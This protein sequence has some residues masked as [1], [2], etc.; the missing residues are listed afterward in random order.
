MAELT[1]LREALAAEQA[2]VYGY[3]VVGAHLSGKA[4]KYAA[5]RLVAHQEL[6]DQLAALIQQ[7]GAVPASA[8]PA[9]Q[10]PF[11]VTDAVEARRLGGTLENGSAGAA[12]DLTAAT[13][14]AS[15]GRQLAVDWLIDVAKAAAL[16][17]ASN[18]L[19]G[20]SA[21]S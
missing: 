17:G 18:A 1:A 20:Q 16:W 19:P 10:L 7:I 5:A 14:S 4:E 11:P 9:Y 21:T 12:W 6:R 3:G 8:L 15:P 13:S 2:V